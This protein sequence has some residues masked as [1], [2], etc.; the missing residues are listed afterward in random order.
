MICY[1]PFSYIEESNIIKL[2]AA[3]GPVTVYGP[4]AG[5][6]PAHM[7]AW[8][9]KGVLEL[10]H[11]RTLQSDELERSVYEFKAW[12]ALHQGNIG[13]MAAFFKSRGTL[14]PL[15]EE[16]HPTQIENQIRNFGKPS[17]RGPVDPV[18][19][20]ALF[21]AMAQEYDQQ[22]DAIAHE[23]NT[24]LS[25]EKAMMER[26]SGNSEDG[27]AGLPEQAAS[28]QRMNSL[29]PGAY[30]TEKRIRAWAEL[31]KLNSPKKNACRLFGRETVNSLDTG[32][33]CQRPFP[34]HG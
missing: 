15:V 4:S 19:Q 6:V 18:F 7:R 14:P 21:L 30:L 24:V 17:T 8:S 1:M 2:T 20:A 28:D 16:T 23:I 9:Q 29:D 11:P 33:I 13:D 26:L 5:M 31:A 22:H 3:L 32:R 27:D 34:S 10:R 25:M 12:A